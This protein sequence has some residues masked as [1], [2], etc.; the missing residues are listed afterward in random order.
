MAP[1]Y[2]LIADMR[3][4]TA[5]KTDEWSRAKNRRVEIIILDNLYEAP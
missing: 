4:C 3:I 2:V 1:V 5:E